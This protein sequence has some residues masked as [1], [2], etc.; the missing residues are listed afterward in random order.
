MYDEDEE[1]F[2]DII[3]TYTYRELF[4][5]SKFG[6]ATAAGLFQAAINIVVVVVTNQI[7]K[8]INDGEGL[9]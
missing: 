3:D 6:E 1:L 4:L 7:A 8:A 2:A 9:Y 5:K